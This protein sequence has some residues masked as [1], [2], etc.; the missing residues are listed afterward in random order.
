MRIYGRPVH[1]CNLPHFKGL[2]L[3]V[4]FLASRLKCRGNVNSSLASRRVF[5]SAEAVR[6]YSSYTLARGIEK[7]FGKINS[8]M[9]CS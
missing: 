4:I 1:E 2:V 3:L 7:L 5:Q 6:V 9:I 8:L